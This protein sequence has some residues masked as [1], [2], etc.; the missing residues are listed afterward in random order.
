MITSEMAREVYECWRR[1]LRATTD[2]ERPAWEDAGEG[3]QCVW[4]TV[5]TVASYVVRRE[6]G[7]PSGYEGR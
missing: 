2:E 5:M 7:L 1:N 4:L 6:L 3:V